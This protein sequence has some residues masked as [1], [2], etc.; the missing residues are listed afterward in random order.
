[1]KRMLIGLAAGLASGCGGSQES[2]S[3]PPKEEAKPAPAVAATAAQT[4]MAN[5]PAATPTPT[6]AAPKKEVEP[7]GLVLPE[8]D[9]GSGKVPEL[10]IR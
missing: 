3:T 7:P 1:M 8:D 2:A 6:A 5:P 10:P 9:V 4:E